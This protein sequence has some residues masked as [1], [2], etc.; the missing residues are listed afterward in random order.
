MQLQIFEGP[1]GTYKTE[2]EKLRDAF[3]SADAVLI[4]AGAGLSTS[5]GLNYAG[6]RL[7][8]YFGDF[9]DK[10]GMSD[11]YQGCFAPFESREERWAY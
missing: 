11:M 4:G 6:E 8:R 5:A 3:H 1:T 7:I 9:V 10:Y 2:I